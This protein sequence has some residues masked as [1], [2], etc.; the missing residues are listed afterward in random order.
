MRILAERLE[1]G[2][3]FD[4][5]LIVPN[6]SEVGPKDVDLSTR[7]T[8]G[9][10]LKIPLVCAAMDTVTEASTAIAIA[11]EGGLGIIHK[12]WS[13]S[14]QAEEVSRVKKY[15]GGVV[16]EPITVSPGH[17]IAKVKELS[18]QY[19]ISGF[20]VTEGTRL[21]GIVTH[22]DIQFEDDLGRKVKEVMTPRERLVTAKFGITLTEAKRILHDKRIEKLLLVDGEFNLKGMITVRDIEKL[23]LF[24]L[25]TK[26][27]RARLCVGAAVGVGDGENER[28]A[29]L[30]EAG[31]D[32]IVVDTAHG[33]SRG[34]VKMVEGLRGS[35]HGLRIIAGNIATAEAAK[36][37]I[38]AGASALKVGVGPGSIC[39]TR[40]VSGCGVPQISAIDAV[41]S[42][43]GKKDIPVIADGGIKYSGDI[44]KALAAGA[45]TVMIGSMFAG[46]DESPGEVVLFQGR[47]YKVYRGMG[48]ISAME[49]G[50]RDRYFQNEVRESAKL[51]PEGVE[52]RVP[53]RGRLCDVVYQLIGGIRAGM[54]YAGCAS[55]AELFAK[56]KFVRITAA[57]L[58]ES[59][60]HDVI[61]TKETPNYSIE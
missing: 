7:L 28:A 34:V 39:T 42:V 50:S 37:L 11:K 10:F 52:G 51:V 5:V 44:V 40:I 59:H 2:L 61:I 45:E 32:V 35:Y 46:T 24:P 14:R 9:F 6:A 29:A 53:Y 25:A 17:S 38:D 43:A 15:E 12:N 55:V 36:A 47:S 20:P 54:G 41:V 49:E 4:D 13:A 23:R 48:S 19:R 60:V 30:I 18:R 26:D 58:R 22:R 8:T 31:A 56:T 3:T 16:L 1:D 27:D 33:H 21:V 57:A